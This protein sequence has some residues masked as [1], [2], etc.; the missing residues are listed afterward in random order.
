VGADSAS[1]STGLAR[2]KRSMR[3]RVGWL[4]APM[5]LILAASSAGIWS[6]LGYTQNHALAAAEASEVSN[7]IQSLV[8][9]AFQAVEP[10]AH[11]AGLG[12]EGTAVALRLQTHLDQLRSRGIETEYIAPLERL[13]QGL[14][15]QFGQE[16]AVLQVGDLV[17]ARVIAGRAAETTLGPTGLLRDK[18]VE[19]FRRSAIAANRATRLAL[20]GLVGVVVATMAGLSLWSQRR[21]RRWQARQADYDARAHFEAMVRHSSD[22]IVVKDSSGIISYVSPSVRA[23]LG[24]DP[25]D[26]VGRYR[27]GVV[28]PDQLSASA[29]AYQ[30]AVDGQEP[31][32]L[33][34]SIQHADGGWRTMEVNFAP[35]GGAQASRSMLLTCRDV[36]DRRRLEK[37]LNRQAFEDSLTGLPNRALLQDRLTQAL[38]RTERTDHGVAVLLLDLDGFKDIN[39]GFG[40]SVGDEVLVE[41]ARRLSRAVR[42]ADT[43]ARFGGDEFVV[44]VEDGNP[45]QAAQEVAARLSELL[46][47]P[48]RVGRN[49]HRILVSTGIA[50]ANGG[51]SEELIRNADLAMY[52]AKALGRGQTV[53]FE[54]GMHDDARMRV[55]LAMDLDGA[56]DRGELVVYYQPT[57]DLHTRE[58]VGAEALVRWQHPTRGLLGPAVFIPLAERGGQIAA[59]GSWVLAEAC[60]QAAG[61]MWR[62]DGPSPKSINVNV[63]GHQLM[64]PGFVRIVEAALAESG[65]TPDTLVLEITET[66]LMEDQAP[67]LPRL[68]D[69]KRLGVRI[70][71]DD[72]GTGYSS[73]SRLAAFPVDVLKIDRSFVVASAQGDP[74]ARALVKS[75]V[76]LCRDLHMTAVAEGIEEPAEAAEMQA[77]G[78]RFGQGYL[79]GRPMAVEQFEQAMQIPALN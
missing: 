22:L 20:I 58:P 75:I 2:L 25:E 36:T 45:E 68:Q 78:C 71:L 16:Y 72:Y 41:L 42:P 74:G 10:G 56:I 27:L 67:W 15:A 73:M 12:A 13:V 70:A 52:R 49:E 46:Q 6:L 40:H 50:V 47:Q 5:A 59:I 30:M 33:D 4:A 63:S 32:V 54:S 11:L 38:A 1:G 53:I 31:V 79:M 48:I 77:C 37:E 21:H 66:V 23:L 3:W 7:D 57:F 24:H 60:R 34:L 8:G 61:W 43:T 14:F 64:D 39:D 51:T 29:A 9:I 69:L 62:F 18:M 19:E 44:V 17:R 55:E 76:T 26:W 65:L 28:H 35:L